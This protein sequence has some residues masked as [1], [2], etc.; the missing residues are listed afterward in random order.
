MH[1]FPI[2]TYINQKL[3][4]KVRSIQQELYDLTGSKAC[5]ELWEPHITVGSG[6]NVEEEELSTLFNDVSRVV[7]AAKPFRIH[8]ENFNFMDNWSG[9]KMKD[10]SPYVIYLDVIT[11][12]QLQ[13]LV[14]TLKIK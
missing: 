3:T 8:I 7:K 2:V 1:H 14:E 5:L 11:S 12:P 9:S 10:F 13:Q 4:Q 6:I